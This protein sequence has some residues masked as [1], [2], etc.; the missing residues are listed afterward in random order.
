MPTI[1]PEPQ[2]TPPRGAL[3]RGLTA[4]VVLIVLV[5]VG[6]T[7]LPPSAQAQD[8]DAGTGSTGPSWAV[9]P[10]TATGPTGRAAFL[11]DV[12]PGQV[13]DDVL[14]LSN[15]ADEPQ[16]FRVYGSDAFS[17]GDGSFALLRGDQTSKDVG[18]W[19]RFDADR[20]T[21]P[22]HSRLDLP[23]KIHVPANA[24]PGDH[25]GGAVAAVLE[26]GK[27]RKGQRVDI[28]RRVAARIYLRVQGPLR[29]SV[30]VDQVRI[31]YENPINAVAGA[32]MVV[33][34]RV[35]NTGNARLTGT[36]SVSVAG[37]GGLG[38]KSAKRTSLPELLPGAS[39]VRTATITGVRPL[40]RLTAEVEVVPEPVGGVTGT[41]PT[42]I[43]RTQVV[44]AVPWLALGVIAAI[45]VAWRVRR[46][47]GDR[48]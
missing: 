32:P 40:I 29:P 24:T 2:P 23:F 22:P 30:A 33:T 5:I 35:R 28:D 13:V 45:V 31:R 18:R 46:R 25:A 19:V 42:T 11:Y 1:H 27:D 15:L 17:T 21:V 48:T 10:S 3:H 26:P 16:T 41:P 12:E 39:L 20:Y 37:P 6:S 36:A 4:L 9:E 14:G 8:G 7:V 43:A 38:S 44:W 47:V 34:Y